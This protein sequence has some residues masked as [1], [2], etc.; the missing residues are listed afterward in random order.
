MGAEVPEDVAGHDGPGGWKGVQLLSEEASEGGRGG[1]GVSY[2]RESR[3]RKIGRSE[4]GETAPSSP[5][6]SPTGEPRGNQT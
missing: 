6:L 2:D 3:D 4:G 5:P 1:P